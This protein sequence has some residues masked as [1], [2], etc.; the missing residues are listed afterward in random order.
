MA[1]ILKGKIK[2]SPSGL[3]SVIFSHVASGDRGI[4]SCRVYKSMMMLSIAT[5]IYVAGCAFQ[6]QNAGCLDSAPTWQS[7]QTSA[8]S[9]HPENCD[10]NEIG[11]IAGKG[12][13]GKKQKMSWKSSVNL[14]ERMAATELEYGTKNSWFLTITQPSTDTRAY[15]A[16][17][18]YSSYAMDRLN[19][20]FNRYF[21]GHEF[22]RCSVWEYQDRGSL[23]CHIL[24]SSD[25]IHAMNINDFRL[26]ICKV[27]YSILKA[28]SVKFESDPFLS[29]Y[30][31]NWSLEELKELKNDDEKYI[32]VDCQQVVKSIVAYLSSYLSGSNHDSK[33]ESKNDKR[34]KFFP[35]ATWSQWNRKATELY[36]KYNDVFD[37]GECEPDRKKELINIKEQLRFDLLK[38]IPLARNTEIKEPQNPYNEGLYFIPAKPQSKSLARLLT[39]YIEKLRHIFKDNMK[40]NEP[41][42]KQDEF[43]YG[44][45]YCQT[46]HHKYFNRITSLKGRFRRLANKLFFHGNL[47]R[48]IARM[49][50]QYEEKQA[51]LLEKIS[52]RF[53]KTYK[54]LELN[55]ESQ[56]TRLPF[57]QREI[58]IT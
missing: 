23:H 54:Q 51:T 24:I 11:L 3:C 18:R 41:E 42:K 39:G 4:K 32:F 47:D 49:M 50:I 45:N 6:C 22:S 48:Q 36:D 26:H 9:P 13:L 12:G 8:K 33:S 7:C 19:R 20:E 14:R 53:K 38:R 15:E 28:I 37:L 29:S 44:G 16:L 21:D 30:G 46:M 35:I 1:S 31:H 34:E 43:G 40:P 5:S 58:F 57:L 52:L 25:C 17:A 55:Y 56:N 27:W 10:R 2:Q